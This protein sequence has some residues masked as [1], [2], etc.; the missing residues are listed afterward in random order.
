MK[1]L[2]ALACLFTMLCT[3]CK[4]QGNN[5]LANNQFKFTTS[6]SIVLPVKVSGK[7]DPCLFVP[8]GPGGGYLSFEQL[9]G[10]NLESFLTMIYM[11]P[12]GSGSA[13]NANNYHMDRLLKDMD[14]LRAKLGIDK[15]YLMSHSFGG[16]IMI[17]YAKKY[18]QHTKGL[19]LVNSTLY[20]F[21][22]DALAE[23]I[24]FG[25]K[26]IG[27]DTTIKVKNT[28]SLFAGD[29]AMR[30]KLSKVHLG[31]KLLT[32]SIKTL[33]QFDKLDSLHPRTNDFAYKI[34]SPVMDKSKKM[35]YPEYFKDYNKLSPDINVP[36]LI[37]NGT[38][39]HAV[40]TNTYKLMKFPNQKVVQIDG[41]HLLYYEK[42][43]AFVD[44]VKNFIKET[45]K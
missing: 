25:Y 17:N 8:G 34:L 9:G 41:G 22:P 27:K 12:R 4:Q 15:I 28:D 7:G 16:I 19:I 26:L 36:V 45:D 35:I 44:A 23:Q 11:D 18:P 37:I 13:Q 5:Q 32:D 20:F 38:N 21:N 3:A 24:S 2:L 33:V 29:M 14:D 42:N 1:K 30:A 6:D 31:Y 39:D 40:G 10:N 43:K